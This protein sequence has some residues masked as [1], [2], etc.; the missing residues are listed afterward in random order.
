MA[1]AR[2]FAPPKIPSRRGVAL[3]AGLRGAQNDRVSA[4]VRCEML[5][6]GGTILAPVARRDA[7]PMFAPSK[8]D[9]LMSNLTARPSLHASRGVSTSAATD[10]FA[11]AT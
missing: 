6:H 7:P 9:A 11:S 8:Y 2:S 1:H 5:L 4:Q 10:Q 3:R